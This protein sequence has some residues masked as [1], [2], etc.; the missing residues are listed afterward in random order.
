[1]FAFEPTRNILPL[2][3]GLVLAASV[4]L[5]ACTSSPHARVPAID[6]DIA[7]GWIATLLPPK[8]DHRDG[9]AIDIFAALEALSLRPTKENVCAVIAVTEQE[10]TF[11]V[12]PVVP[13]LPAIAQREIHARA[14]R[15]GIPALAVRAALQLRSPTG[16]TYDERLNR[17]RTEKGLSDIFEDFIDMVPLGTRL[18]G[19]LNPVR[20]GGPMQVSIAFAERQ[21]QIKR[22]PYPHEGSIRDEV[23]TRRGGLY[24]GIAHLLDYPAPYDSMLFRFADFNVG[25]YASRNAAFQNAVS[26]LS[27]TPLALDG[28]LLLR[29]QE[30]GQ[31]SKTELAIRKLAGKIDLDEREIRDDLERGDEET[32]AATRV[33]QRIFALADKARRLPRAVVPTIRLQS[34]KITRKLSTEW[35]ARRVNDRYSRCLSRAGAG[36]AT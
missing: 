17:V 21:A 8:I 29:G 25:H 9:W 20:T 24:F 23:F 32:F 28:D 33:Y 34:P 26:A 1:M 16:A 13:G 11:E 4:A 7:R 36:P 31:P 30:S 19:R 10:S 12:N 6:P 14:G 22:Y 5:S 18:F 15:Y 2:A 3:R 27:K 35:F